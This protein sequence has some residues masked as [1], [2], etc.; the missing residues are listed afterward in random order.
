MSGHSIIF[1]Q[2]KSMMVSDEI[3]S[4]SNITVTTIHPDE[5]I[6]GHRY[7]EAN[8]VAAYLYVTIAT[9]ATV[10]GFFGNMVV[11]ACVGL[12]KSLRNSRNVFLVNLAIA[13]LIITGF[14]DSFSIAGMWC[15]KQC[16][17]YVLNNAFQVCYV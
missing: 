9:T 3:T 8:P 6:G 10:I 15:T 17:C 4:V 7:I 11:L 1:V 5:F 14:A 16:L 2:S 13:D 12:V